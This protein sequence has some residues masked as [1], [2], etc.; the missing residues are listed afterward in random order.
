[1]LDYLENIEPET[2]NFVVAVA[3]FQ[4][5]PTRWERLLILKHIY[6]ILKYGGEVMMFNWSFSKWFFKK[7]KWQVLKSFILGV[8]SL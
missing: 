3:S 2:F 5:I 6:R 7:Y 1:M 4:H 8:L